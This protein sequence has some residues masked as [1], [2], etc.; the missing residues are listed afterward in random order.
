MHNAVS[1]NQK[2]SVCTIDFEVIILLS[3]TYRWDRGNLTRSLFQSFII[4]YWPRIPRR[5]YVAIRCLVYTRVVT[6]PL[7]KGLY[8]VP[9][10]GPCFCLKRNRTYLDMDKPDKEA[11]RSLVNQQTAVTQHPT[12]VSW[13]RCWSFSDSFSW[14]YGVYQVSAW[15]QYLGIE[16]SS[17]WRSKLKAQRLLSF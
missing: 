14:A 11:K 1:A 4:T 2:S 5:K 12:E 16:A 3:V 15:T 7:Q 13:L 17:S 8:M 9:I 10:R 6:I